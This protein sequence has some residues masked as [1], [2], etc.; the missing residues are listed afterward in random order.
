[1]SR[2]IDNPDQFIVVGENI[3][4]TR[5]VKRGGVR[6]HVFVDSTEAVKYKIGGEQRFMRVPTHF[7]NTQPYEQ[8]NLKHFMIAMWKGLNGDEDESTEGKNYIQYEVNRQIYAGAH[9]LDRNV[10]ESS[11]RLEEQKRSMEWL[12][13]FVESI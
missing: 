7:T 6:G 10:D 3:H 9:Y 11:Y 13:K 1:M 2:V 5:V 8:G 12:D 4:A